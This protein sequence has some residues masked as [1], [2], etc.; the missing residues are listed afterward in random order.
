M[1]LK[2][3]RN[4]YFL[5]SQRERFSM[6]HAAFGRGD[7][8]EAKA[9]HAASPKIE[10]KASDLSMLMS[11]LVF[12]HQFNL[13]TRISYADVVC[14]ILISIK[15]SNRLEENKLFFEGMKLYAYLYA[16]ETD[17][18]RNACEAFGIRAEEFHEWQTKYFFAA[19]RLAD[20]DEWLRDM[21]YSEEE[22]KELH[23]T[24]KTLESITKAN[25]KCLQQIEAENRP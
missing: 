10:Y 16:V 25:L 6:L 1:N 11:W 3:L 22:V 23:P 24:A 14:D 20:L 17:G 7:E 2:N 12:L 4:N 5:L 8:S 15:G 19:E 18:W 13:L 21:A 9:I